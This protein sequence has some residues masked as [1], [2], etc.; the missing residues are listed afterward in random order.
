MLAN[1]CEKEA[2]LTQKDARA[3]G[4]I[5]LLTQIRKNYFLRLALGSSD[6]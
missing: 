3:G 4:Y 6:E 2:Q 1:L 5:T